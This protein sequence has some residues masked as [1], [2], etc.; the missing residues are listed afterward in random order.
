[1]RRKGVLLALAALLCTFV[2]AVACKEK[3]DDF[4][5]F[6]EG[7]VTRFEIGNTLRLAEIIDVDGA[8]DYTLI[9]TNG[10]E[11]VDLTGKDTWYP[12]T[13][14]VWTLT[15]RIT[16]GK[17]KGTYT[18]E[19]DVIVPETDITWKA[20]PLFYAYG[21]TVTFEELLNAAQLEAF[22]VS[23]YTRRVLTVR[24]G[25]KFM[26]EFDEGDTE[27]TFVNYDA[28][29]FTIGIVTDRGQIANTIITVNVQETDAA[30]TYYCENNNIK[31]VG[32]QKLTYRDGK[33]GAVMSPGSY[34]KTFQQA[35]LSYL[36]FEGDYGADTY[37]SVDFTGKNIPHTAFFCDMVTS[38]LHDQNQG[39]YLSH[40]TV[41]SSGGEHIGG[42]WSCL[43][44]FG[45]NK[46]K[47][48]R[49]HS[50]GS[51]GR[52]GWSSNPHPAS[53]EGLQDGVHYRYI[54]GYTNPV[55]G[56]EDATNKR[57]N[58][59]LRMLLVNLDTNEIVVDMTKTL[60]AND[61]T[62]VLKEE[63]FKGSIALYGNYT[64]TTTWDNIRLVE[65]YV[66]DVYDLYPTVR[67]EEEAPAYALVGDVLNATDY[68]DENVLAGGK[69]YYSYKANELA[70]EG[71]DKPFIAPLTIDKAGAYRIKFVP[72][73][74]NVNARS[75]TLY[76]NAASASNHYK[77]DFE[78]GVRNAIQ[79][80]FR[81]G[82]YIDTSDA[83]DTRVRLTAGDIFAANPSSWGVDFE[84][85]KKVFADPTVENVV[86]KLRSEKEIIISAQTGY[87]ENNAALYDSGKVLN[88]NE[89]TFVS[90][91]RKNY[92]AAV[93]KSSQYGMY[94]FSLTT[95]TTDA[96]SKF[97]IAI[98]EVN[99]GTLKEEKKFLYGEGASL[100][101]T[102]EG[103]PT[104]VYFAG[105]DVTS[106]C[107][108]DG[109]KVTVPTSCLT[110]AAGR[111]V[112][113]VAQT[114]NG[115]EIANY[116]L[117]TK[118][119]TYAWKSDVHT[120]ATTI[121]FEVDGNVSAVEVDGTSVPYTVENGEVVI[122]KADLTQFSESNA[123]LTVTTDKGT[124][125]VNLAVSLLKL[126][127][128][129]AEEQFPFEVGN[130]TSVE[131]VDSSVITPKKGVGSYRLTLPADTD[132]TKNTMTIPLSFLEEIFTHPH[133]AT[134]TYYIAASYD[135]AN[136]NVNTTTSSYTMQEKDTFYS[137]MINYNDYLLLKSKGADYVLTVNT[138]NRPAGECYFYFDYMTISGTSSTRDNA[139]TYSAAENPDGI[140]FGG[141]YGKVTAIVDANDKNIIDNFN[142][143]DGG[144]TI[145][146]KP[147]VMQ[148]NI[149]RLVYIKLTT[150][151]GISYTIRLTIVA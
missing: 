109:N 83:N 29:Y 58:I 39:I 126:H 92:L 46:M 18:T 54:V 145:T 62:G 123:Q 14:G 104:K 34:V 86:L 95:P 8:E 10:T 55:A 6:K 125:T 130:V 117:I 136:I 101:Y 142:V 49:V 112:Q 96:V 69:L 59:T 36:A 43:T 140:T 53:R 70:A 149:G 121:R 129:S 114:E 79:G 91:T 76:A 151:L 51:F 75:V 131:F 1:M 52:E 30:A 32:Y 87:N 73:D 139:V 47:E 17:N 111:S 42:D 64:V 22:T 65:E 67:F 9:A 16:S 138:N 118:I 132:G 134:M 57:G 56:T 84:Y 122:K 141:F 135:K 89:T 61:Q 21:S 146:L 24:I 100:S 72:D 77:L 113:L 26:V 7:C 133:V 93:A 40:G 12:E 88:P 60:W 28:H 103:T 44:Y 74:P 2:G 68:L 27:Y 143:N 4:T 98:E 128:D 124:T 50:G 105:A 19:L 33:L 99:V 120:S 137:R 38:N 148:S 20:N 81:A 150:D 3:N 71:E 106:V 25:N 107:T 66:E 11:E 108:I 41:S 85:L 45:P 115:V 116:Q 97:N 48:Y 23:E 147:S 102:F 144:E 82:A 119:E 94:L 31:A 5:G 90:I 80:N 63:H 13:K 78:D 15:L 110:E 127:Y 35:S 37:V